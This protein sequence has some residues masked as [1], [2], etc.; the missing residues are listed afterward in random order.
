[1]GT[2][3]NNIRQRKEPGP[4]LHLR[5]E[6]YATQCRENLRTN[7][8][9]VTSAYHCPP[10]V[11][12]EYYTERTLIETKGPEQL[13][14]SKIL[15]TGASRHTSNF[16]ARYVSTIRR[17]WGARPVPTDQNNAKIAGTNERLLMTNHKLGCL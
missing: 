7:L 11:L 12:D 2:R 14:V 15:F 4:I 9:L 3:I 1:M 17:Y 8:T 6:S 10:L 13:C 16:L 5:C